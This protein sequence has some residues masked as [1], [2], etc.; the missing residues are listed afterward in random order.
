[1]GA[2]RWAP[3]AGHP[4]AGHDPGGDGRDGRPRRARAGSAVPVGRQGGAS[5]EGAAP[6]ED[7][8]AGQRVAVV[9]A[10]GAAGQMTLR[11]LAERRCPVRELRAYASERSVGKTVTFA[12][13]A[14][15]IEKVTA[16]AFRGVE[17]AFFA[18][19]SAQS[20]EYVPLA[21]RAG[22][23]VVDKSNAFRMDPAVPLVVPQ[24]NAHPVKGHQGLVVRHNCPTR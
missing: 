22:A 18:A 15:R 14:I 13:E 11:S 21:V 9:G 12:G 24:I 16:E 19:G 10:T 2:R 17:V 8:M 6:R 1:A 4:H 5:P 3:D 20:R 7:A 23:V